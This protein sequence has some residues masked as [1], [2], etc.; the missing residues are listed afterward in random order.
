MELTT[1]PYQNS[2]FK[3]PHAGKIYLWWAHYQLYLSVSSLSH[4]LHFYRHT[5]KGIGIS[6]EENVHMNALFPFLYCSLVNSDAQDW[7]EMCIYSI[8]L[9]VASIQPALRKIGL[10]RTVVIWINYGCLIVCSHFFM[11][12]IAMTTNGR[13]WCSFTRPSPELLNNSWFFF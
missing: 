6:F 7:C 9:F 10:V 2:L 4:L 13:F 8:R 3:L 12:I 1:S 5:L 11:Q